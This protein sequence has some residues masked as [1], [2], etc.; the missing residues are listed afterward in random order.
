M[1]A[2]FW[3]VI[4]DRRDSWSGYAS[5]LWRHAQ[6]HRLRWL[7]GSATFLIAVLWLGSETF[8]S[9]VHKPLLLLFTSLP[10]KLPAGSQWLLLTLVA[11]LL[12]SGMLWLIRRRR[13]GRRFVI[14]QATAPLSLGAPGLL[15]ILLLGLPLPL[16]L[17]ADGEKIDRPAA[18]GTQ[19]LASLRHLDVREKVLLARPAQP[20]TLADLRGTDPAKREAALRSIQRIDLQNRSLRRANLSST[21]APRAE[22]RGARL[23]GAK[24]ED[25]Q[26]R[27]ADFRGAQLQGV[28]FLGTELHGANLS[29]LNLQ[30]TV[31]GE[32]W[33]DGADLSDAQLQGAKLSE[34]QLQGAKLDRADMQGMNLSATGMRGASL[35]SASLQ[36]A[37]LFGV[38]LQGA[39]LEQAQM[40]GANL[41]QAQ[42]QGA[43]LERA[44]L[45]RAILADA[46]LR[47]AS[48]GLAELQGANLSGAELQG[49]NLS[50]VDLHGANLSKA[51]LQGADLLYA[52]LWAANL[53]D[54]Q[55]QGA[56]LSEASFSG[57]SLKDAQLQG[58]NLSNTDM[59]GC[60]SQGAVLYTQMMNK[61]VV[62]LVDA[63]GLKW[64]PLGPKELQS[65]RESQTGLTWS[66][67]ENQ[68]RYNDAIEKAAVPGLKPPEIESC[69]RDA[70]TQVSCKEVLSIE[71]FRQALL[72]IL[73]SLA[74]RS[75]DVAY[76]I[77]RQLGESPTG[78]REDSATRGL[79]L[80]LQN[81]LKEA[82][83]DHSCPGLTKLPA[84][85][86]ELLS[87][88]VQE[89]I[90]RGEAA[91]TSPPTATA[92]KR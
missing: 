92:P 87:R 8:A 52:K 77:L 39:D 40:D 88:L 4:I 81:K 17:V 71:K 36:G 5:G 46:H 15:T 1:V 43:K 7:C 66:S 38:P 34:V 6:V 31:F 65:L 10:G 2:T 55:L 21:L 80:R 27:G 61:A 70:S 91:K 9:L 67:K 74:C 14:L 73:E 26:F 79:P 41:S 75:P 35:R 59:H 89:E 3:P 78:D 72:P 44:L 25:A 63:R 42:L 53:K 85:N 24:F 37:N 32:V 68:S 16:M 50:R 30:R 49:A 76:G 13:R 51:Q 23:Q 86:K 64:R 57:A 83:K 45:R 33:L 22:L 84:A 62:G 12:G 20:E 90:Q 69:L 54:A 56:N 82:E 58:A 11:L 28:L 60:L 47:G 18:L 19:M 48:L 29:K